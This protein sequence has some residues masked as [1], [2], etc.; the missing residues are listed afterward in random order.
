MEFR[1]G[2]GARRR[3]R[4]IDLG[5]WHFTGGEGSARQVFD[6]LSAKGLGIEFTIDREG[7]IWQ[8]CDPAEVDTFD[9]GHVNDR[10]FGVEIASCGLAPLLRRGADRGTYFGRVHGA[11]E[12][13]ACFYPQQLASAVALANTMSEACGIPRRLPSH[14]SVLTAAELAAFTGHLGHLHVSRA[15]VDPGPQLFDALRSAGYAEV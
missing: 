11:S 8:H 3:R 6:V 15:K 7:V 9:A 12:E 13:F 14:L 1:P 2:R 10:S 4:K 5:V